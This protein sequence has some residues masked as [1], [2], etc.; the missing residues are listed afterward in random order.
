[1][2]FIEDL[3]KGF[4]KSRDRHIY[5]INSYKSGTGNFITQIVTHKDE[6]L[7]FVDADEIKTKR[8]KGP[9]TEEELNRRWQIFV[10]KNTRGIQHDTLLK[11]F[12][13]SNKENFFSKLETFAMKE[14][15]E[16]ES[17]WN[18]EEYLDED[19]KH[20]LALEELRF[21]DF[22]SDMK[23]KL[24]GNIVSRG[25][26]ER[27]AEYNSRT[28]KVIES[29]LESLPRCYDRNGEQVFEFTEQKLALYERLKEI[30]ETIDFTFRYQKYRADQQE[31]AMQ[32]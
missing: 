1:M 17:M 12:T 8:L 3:I 20:L 10:V 29:F 18:I 24:V 2:D 6:T 9:E 14:N 11:N 23:T 19:L 31:E 16:L 32:N 22:M 25:L 26:E 5:E 15:A 28:H 30:A 13:E 7:T 4:L 27:S 21:T